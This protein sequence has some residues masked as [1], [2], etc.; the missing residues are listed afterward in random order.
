LG[1]PMHLFSS[2]VYKCALLLTIIESRTLRFS[3]CFFIDA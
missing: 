3:I 1:E 2:R